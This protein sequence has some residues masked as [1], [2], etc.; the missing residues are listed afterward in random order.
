MLQ[1][2]NC[3]T[4]PLR[5]DARNTGDVVIARIPGCGRRRARD[6]PS[7]DPLVQHSGQF[8]GGGVVGDGVGVEED[9]EG[10]LDGVGP[11]AIALSIAD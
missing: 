3:I 8:V 6:E 4:A 1:V 10:I 7:A 5:S 11:V 2:Q 9:G